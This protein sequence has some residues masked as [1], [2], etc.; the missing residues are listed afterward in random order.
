MKTIYIIIITATAI[1]FASCSNSATDKAQSAVKGYLKENFKN[2]DSYE[3]ISFTQ[4]DTLKQA[5]TSDT[6]LISLYKITHF[7]SI[8]NSD[9][10]KAKM[11]VSFYL[12]KDLK[13][14]KT[15]TKSING[16][17][18]TLTG[19]AYWKYNNYVG[20]KADAGAEITLYS[21]D[22]IRGNLKFEAT[23]DV[24]GNYKIEKI[25]P[26][27]YLLIVRSKNATDCPD[28]HFS[29]LRIYGAKIKQ[30][31][32]FDIEKY[33]TQLDEINVLDSLYFKSS[34]NFPSNG[35]LSQMTASIAKTDAILKQRTEKIEKLFE[36]FPADFKSKIKLYTGYSNAYDFSTIRI[37]EGKTE[38][39]ITDF[40][41]TCI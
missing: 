34:D 22:T 11:T 5:D 3:P 4:L 37:E 13:V 20:N 14:T 25:I 28:T 29:N 35:S 26:G 33:K 41:I 19:N 23:A 39:I 10:D 7:Y 24:Q 2:S 36:A 18:G 40:G 38:N 27:S 12:D 8:T 32:G 1:C 15:N 30:L 16:D 9:K 21:L 17:Y 31:F 6:K